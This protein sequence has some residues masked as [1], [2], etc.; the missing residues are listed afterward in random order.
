MYRK[1]PKLFPIQCKLHANTGEN[2]YQVIRAIA[3]G[4]KTYR[5]A[6]LRASFCIVD[7]Q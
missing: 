2:H 4:E 6:A 5:R 7:R 3:V 1:K